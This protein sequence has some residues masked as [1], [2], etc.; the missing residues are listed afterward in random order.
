M[1]R[2]RFWLGLAVLSG[3]WLF[4]LSYYHDAVWWAWAVCVVL[5]VALLSGVP[6]QGCRYGTAAAAALLVV[7]A[8]L[9]APWPY[10]AAP[11]LIAVAVVLT[12]LPVPRHWPRALGSGAALAGVVLTAQSLALHVY[13]LLTARSHELPWPLPSVLAAIASLLGADAVLDGST[14]SLYTPRV[15]HRLGA[16]WELL[17][18]PATLC[19]IIGGA[20]FVAWGLPRGRRLRTGAAVLAWIVLWMPLRAG[21]LM[22]V[23][24]HRALRTG[25]DEPLS[26]MGPF[27]SAW[28]HVVLL[29]VPALLAWRSTARQARWGPALDAEAR[30]RPWVRAAV[31]PALGVFCIVFGLAWDQAGPRKP[32]RVM[33]DEFHSTWER[34]DRPFDVNWYGPESGYNYACIY[35]YCSR[36]YSMSRLTAALDEQALAACDVLVVKTPTSRYAPEE[37]EVVRQFVEKGGGLLLVGEHTNVFNTGVYLNDLAARFGFGFR[38][39]CLFDIDTPFDQLHTRPVLAHPIIQAVPALDF[40]VSCSIDPGRSLGRAVILSTGLRSLPADYHASNFYPQVEDR[41][42]ARYGAFVQ[43]WAT[44]FGAG[45]VAAFTDSTIFSN[46]STFEPGKPELMLG[47]LEWL[48]HRNVRVSVRGWLVGAGVL[49]AAV[50][51]RAAGSGGSLWLLALSAGWL[52]WAAA[53]AGIHTV[54]EKS[55]P[56]PRPSRPFVRVVF[57]TEVCAPLLS[58]SGFIAG[59]AGGFG[60]FE[61]WVLRLGCFTRRSG[62]VDSLEGDLVVFAEPNRPIRREL[63]TRLV[64]IV[65]SGGHVLVLD[66]PENTGSTA[67]TL[68]YSFGLAVDQGDPLRG[69]LQGPPGWPAVEVESASRV[70]GGEPLIQTNGAPVAARVR[71]GTGTVTVIGFA[72][73]FDDLHMG[74]TGD[75]VPGPDLRQVYDLQFALLRDILSLP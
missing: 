13:R 25:Y 67:N 44:R 42:D 19:F 40:A 36:F 39:D 6:S 71:W 57:D 54:H 62:P 35:D 22:A 16:T 48:N 21:L 34:T 10:R 37:V 18:D 59:K 14:I 46:F 2:M 12:A 8:I 3:S 38:D 51:I 11:L 27:W 52:G 55:M 60:I 58:K 64:E 20:V 43:L 23:L 56:L 74:G 75:V 68:L 72:R 9:V 7:P 26:L 1:A 15:V 29:A 33:V 63:R 17:L 30:P 73:R 47:M 49:L 61:R 41:A 32:G 65:R 70:K 50:G 5:G 4:G 45:R 69:S 66:S 31:G 53:A 28:V 24:L